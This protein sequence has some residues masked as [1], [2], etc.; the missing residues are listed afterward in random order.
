MEKTKTLTMEKLMDTAMTNDTNMVCVQQNGSTTIENIIKPN[1]V[2]TG[3]I[4]T[5][6]INQITASN[7]TSHTTNIEYH[8][9][10]YSILTFNVQ[11][12]ATTQQ[13]QNEQRELTR[14]RYR[15]I[16]T[17]FDIW[18]HKGYNKRKAKHALNSKIFMKYLNGTGFMS[19]DYVIVVIPMTN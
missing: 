11:Y 2:G 1:T 18:T 14:C 13:E 4:D 7:V 3:E 8:D 9:N 6:L 15:A 10:K 19:S 12:N 16:S 5:S 17:I